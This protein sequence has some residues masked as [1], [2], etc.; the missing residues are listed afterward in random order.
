LADLLNLSIVVFREGLRAKRECTLFDGGIQR[1]FATG[2][3]NGRPSEKTA[4][5]FSDGLLP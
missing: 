3:V 2:R 1:D 4:V 5:R